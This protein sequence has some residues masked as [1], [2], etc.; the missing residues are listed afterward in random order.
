MR[1][2][3]RRAG[4][5]AGRWCVFAVVL[6]SRP[7]KL[8][9]IGS[10]Q[11]DGAACAAAH[12]SGSTAK[13]MGSPHSSARWRCC[14]C[15]L[16][17]LLLVVVTRSAVIDP[18]P[19][20]HTSPPRPGGRPESPAVEKFCSAF[21]LQAL[22]GRTRTSATLLPH[23]RQYVLSS[24]TERVRKRDLTYGTLQ[25]AGVEQMLRHISMGPNDVFFDLGSGAGGVVAQV[26]CSTA[27]RR[28]VGVELSLKRVQLAPPNITTQPPDE[29]D[30][31]AT[32]GGREM[33]F[34]TAN[35]LDVDLSSAT[36]VFSNSIVFTD[37]TALAMVSKI[38]RECRPGTIV[39]S[40]K[41]LQRFAGSAGHQRLTPCKEVFEGTAQTYL[42][43][44]LQRPSQGSAGMFAADGSWGNTW[45]HV[46]RLRV[47][48]ITIRVLDCLGFTYVLRYRYG[49]LIIN[50]T[51]GRYQLGPGEPTCEAGQALDSGCAGDDDT[52]VMGGADN[53]DNALRA[54][55]TEFYQKH[56]PSKLPK[57][58]ASLFRSRGR[59]TELLR[60]LTSK[61]VS[62]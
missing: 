44:V 50:M 41:M 28:A 1:G 43:E 35:F 9:N 5:D 34:L 21:D 3:G 30:A 46:Y 27:V 32:A 12:A 19:R 23:E 17:G 26:F 14:C 61:Y 47:M 11:A 6:S 49:Y 25:L 37:A 51:R 15:C 42:D 10:S 33:S 62:V 54:R 57:V 45:I 4:R 20:P 39:L 31:I 22:I 38:E 60:H 52:A 18:S 48:M 40:T 13:M 58:E 7:S 24:D 2:G 36:V 29:D 16:C 55:V 8:L 53:A 59:E 56:N